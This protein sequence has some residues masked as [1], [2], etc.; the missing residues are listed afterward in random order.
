MYINHSLKA[1][2]QQQ[3][4]LKL[5]VTENWKYVIQRFLFGFWLLF[6]IISHFLKYIM[7]FSAS[8]SVNYFLRSVRKNMIY[9]YSFQFRSCPISEAFTSISRALYKDYSCSSKRQWWNEIYCSTFQEKNDLHLQGVFNRSDLYTTSYEEIRIHSW[10]LNVWPCFS[11]YK[12]GIK[13][14]GSRMKILPLT[15]ERLR[16]T[17]GLDFLWC[18]SS[19]RKKQ[20]CK[21]SQVRWLVS[22]YST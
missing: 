15:S 3:N 22:L 14:S 7:H 9:T 2:G 19:K 17:L 18:A 20:G 5:L 1:C 11:L 21:I 13:V 6:I 16:S 8:F 4:M 10:L 12:E